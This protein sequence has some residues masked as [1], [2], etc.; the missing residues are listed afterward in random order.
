MGENLKPVPDDDQWSKGFG[1]IYIQPLLR[2]GRWFM[3]YNPTIGY[4]WAAAVTTDSIRFVSIY[5]TDYRLIIKCFLAKK[6]PY[7]VF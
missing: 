3:N 6:S 5:Y 4:R 2:T 7:R 1:M